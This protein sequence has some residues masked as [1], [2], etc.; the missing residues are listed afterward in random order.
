MNETYFKYHQGLVEMYD[1]LLFLTIQNKTDLLLPRPTTRQ[2]NA[3]LS[4]KISL[5]N[6]IT[7]LLNLRE[8]YTKQDL[9]KSSIQFT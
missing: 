3:I 4:K 8:Q 9:Y 2:I 1:N 6:E 7:E 5:A